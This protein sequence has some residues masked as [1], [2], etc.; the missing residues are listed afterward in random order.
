MRFLFIVQGEGR[1]HFTQT[2]VMKELL[3]KNG[4]EICA[5]LVGKSAIRQLP[6]FFT[7]QI[8]APIFTFESPNFLPTPQNKRP[9]LLKSITFNVKKLPVFISG[10]RFI[11]DKISELQPDLVVN[12]YELL[13]GL[14][15]LFLP[16]AIPYI[17][18]GHQYM[19]LHKDFRFPPKSRIELASLRFFTRMTAIGASRKLALSFYP[20]PNQE[21]DRISIVPPLLKKDVLESDPVN[22]DYIHGY[23]LNNGYKAEIESWKNRHPGTS[24]HFFWDKKDAPT[25]LNVSPG[26]TLHRINDRLFLEYMAGCKAYATTA[27]FESVCEALFLNKPILMVPAHIEQECNAF[28]AMHVGA[29]ISS[30][31]F[32][33]DALL[34]FIPSYQPDENFRNWA[35]SAR[36]VIYQEIL[37]AISEHQMQ[38]WYSIK[39]LLPRLRLIP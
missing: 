31:S 19:F 23:M 32:D 27:G 18:V 25:C 4:H 39:Q 14:T 15:Y 29:G 38:S 11:H 33:L 2:L 13:A 1:G 36:S 5:V 3:Q 7:N 35:Q 6:D 24:L 30:G 10:I 20:F 16:P 8:H 17:C 21:A 34:N 9:P 28:D 12:F 22:G 26:F 37:S